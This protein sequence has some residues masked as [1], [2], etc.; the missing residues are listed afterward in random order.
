MHDSECDEP[1]AADD[2]RILQKLSHIIAA[3]AP[4]HPKFVEQKMAGDAD[5]IRYGHGDQRRQKSAEDEHHGK[6]DQRHGAADGAKTNELENS[7]LIQHGPIPAKS[8]SS[9]REDGVLQS[10]VFT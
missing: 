6:V 1:T 7:F 8:V 10:L 5:E 2:D 3:L 4:E 9:T